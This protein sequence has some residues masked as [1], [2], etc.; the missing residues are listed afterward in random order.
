MR[1]AL[2]VVL[3]ACQKPAERAP[4]PAIGV[5][6]G[7]KGSTFELRA[8]HTLDIDPGIAPNCMNAP[9]AAC[10]ARQTWK[11]NGTIIDLSRGVLTGPHCDCR[12]ERLDMPMRGDEIIYGTEHLQRVKSPN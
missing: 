12:I 7:E 8:D 11:R 9:L 2:L 3:I 6:R 10:R 5:W 4:D 1:I